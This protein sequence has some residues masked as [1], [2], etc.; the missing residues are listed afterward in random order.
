MSPAQNWQTAFRTTLSP[1]RSRTSPTRSSTRWSGVSKIY[2]TKQ[3]LKDIYLA[4]FYGAKIGVIGLNGSG[5]STL[6]RI[7][8]GRR[9][10]VPRRDRDRARVHR[11]LPRA[12]AAARPRQDRPRDRR[13]GRPARPSSCSR[14]SRRSTTSSPSRWNPTRWTSCSSARARCRR[15]ST[16]STPGTSTRASR[17]RWTPCAAR[18]ATRRSRCSPA[19]SCAAWRSAGCSCRSPTSCSSTSP[20]TTSTP[21]PWR[22]SSSTC[23]ST[24]APSSPSPTTATSSTTWRAGSWSSTAARASRGRATTP[25]GS[26]RSRSACAREEKQESERQKTLQRELEWIRMAP[27]ARH[28]KGKAR[29]NAYEQLLTAK[30]EEVARDLEIYIPPGPRLGDVVIEAKGLAKGFGDKLLIENVDFALP[31]GAIVGVIGPNG[32]G[33]TTLVPHDH[34]R[35]E[36]RTPARCASARPC[37]SPTWTRSRTLDPEKTVYEVI[38][39]GMDD[40]TLGK[41]QDE[42]P[43]LLLALQL[44]GRR[45]AEEGRRSSPAASATA[46]TWPACSRQAPTSLLLDEP[47]NDLDVNT[48]RALEDALEQLRRLRGRDQPR[49]LVP[50]PHRHA[51]P[52]LRGRLARSPSSTAT[53]PTT[54]SG[55]ARPSA[56]RPPARTGSRTGS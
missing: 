26:S 7:M 45:P 15:S 42:R 47:T 33:K 54:R 20:P 38:S 39:E 13:G 8:A 52:R 44:L 22:G 53:S 18:P 19:A 56:R 5:K 55:A 40:V 6:L 41:V 51:H 35:A 1:C 50:R 30:P 28:A 49:P 48:L 3:V 24:R 37:S 9:E 32:A 10:G 21:R 46:C 2:G 36:A 34:R 23:S 29:I 25:P 31:P 27:K 14:S 12:G 17:W 43:R 4:Y 11:R 16:R